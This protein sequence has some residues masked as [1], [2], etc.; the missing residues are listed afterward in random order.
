MVH[1]STIVFQVIFCWLS[2][3]SAAACKSVMH[4]GINA[5]LHSLSL[6]VLLDQEVSHWLIALEWQVIGVFVCNIVIERAGRVIS[7]LKLCSGMQLYWSKWIEMIKDS[8]WCSS[9]VIT[10]DGDAR[11]AFAGLGHLCWPFCAPPGVTK[12]QDF[13]LQNAQ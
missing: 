11:C 6:S 4:S 8:A 5:M 1:F 13:H 3:P 12:A 7:T 9:C 2:E 10:V